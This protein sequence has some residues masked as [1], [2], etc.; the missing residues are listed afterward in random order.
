MKSLCLVPYSKEAVFIATSIKD[1]FF[2]FV[3]FLQAVRSPLTRTD[4]TDT[5]MAEETA[6]TAIK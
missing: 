3:F 4:T 5:E 1:F 2:F 6:F